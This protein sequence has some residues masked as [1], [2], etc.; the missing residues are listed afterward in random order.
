MTPGAAP[1]RLE[2]V[3]PVAPKRSASRATIYGE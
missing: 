2:T 3:L 1:E